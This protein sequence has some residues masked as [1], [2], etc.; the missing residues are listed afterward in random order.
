MVD[1]LATSKSNCIYCFLVCLCR[2]VLGIVVMRVSSALCVCVCVC[3][4]V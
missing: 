1:V 3:V 4:C 2:S